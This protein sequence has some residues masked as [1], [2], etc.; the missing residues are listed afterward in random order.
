MEA[1]QPKVTQINL[2]LPANVPSLPETN[3]AKQFG[4]DTLNALRKADKTV[5]RFCRSIETRGK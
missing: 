2:D 3:A 1:T 4:Q 5:E